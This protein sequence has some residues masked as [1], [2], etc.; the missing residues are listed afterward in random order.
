MSLT[1][2]ASVRPISTPYSVHGFKVS[3]PDLPKSIGYDDLHNV[4]YFVPVL[5][6]FFNWACAKYLLWIVK[7]NLDGRG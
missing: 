7:S 3:H 4:L 5:V 6:P 2:G 1:L